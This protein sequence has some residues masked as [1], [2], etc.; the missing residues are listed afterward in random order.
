M[1]MPL[2][3]QIANMYINQLLRAIIS[4]CT[5]TNVNT[6]YFKHDLAAKSIFLSI[7]GNLKHSPGLL[8]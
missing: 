5:L 1:I 2:C 3:V 4:F 6:A 8:Q 7:S